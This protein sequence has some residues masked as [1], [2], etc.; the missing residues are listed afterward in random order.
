MDLLYV[1]MAKD[2]FSWCSPQE[3]NNENFKSILILP[4]F[5]NKMN[6]FNFL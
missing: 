4:T 5:F 6:S 2:T 1:A 3:K